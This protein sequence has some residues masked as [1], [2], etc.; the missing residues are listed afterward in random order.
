[1][2]L[3]VLLSMMVVPSYFTISSWLNFILEPCRFN[4]EILSSMILFIGK[5]SSVFCEIARLIPLLGNGM[6]DP[7]TCFRVHALLPRIIDLSITSSP[8]PR[9]Y[10][11]G[12][13]MSRYFTVTVSPSATRSLPDSR[14]VLKGTSPRNVPVAVPV[15]VILKE[16]PIG[17]E[18]EL[19][20][21]WTTSIILER[22]ISGSNICTS[23]VP[24]E[25]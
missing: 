9:L 20:W 2:T 1:M 5:Y 25:S 22:F 16:M 12:N 13:D 19:A 24:S 8:S 10:G 17:Y 11:V 3:I 4:T 18:S 15:S 21:I 14:V 23:P 6:L 7:S